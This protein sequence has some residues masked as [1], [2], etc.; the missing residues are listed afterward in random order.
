METS[1]PKIAAHGD[2]TALS[3]RILSQI[4]YI[5]S[6]DLWNDD[7]LRQIIAL[8]D[9]RWV[10]I[11]LV[12]RFNR[13]RALTQD[14]NLVVC[15]LKQSDMFEVDV[16]NFRIRRK[17]PL[18]TFN[19]KR[20]AK[21]CIYADTLPPGSNLD[22]IQ[23]MFSVFGEV[24]RVAPCLSSQLI[25]KSLAKHLKMGT[26]SNIP[27]PAGIMYSEEPHA[28]LIE[29]STKQAAKNAVYA[30]TKFNGLKN[31]PPSTTSRLS[32][33]ETLLEPHSPNIQSIARSLSVSERRSLA[34]FSAIQGENA[35]PPQTLTAEVMR[36][37]EKLSAMCILSPPTVSPLP[38]TP[39]RTSNSEETLSQ[40]TQRDLNAELRESV[41]SM[42][43]DIDPA[44]D[45][46]AEESKDISA[47]TPVKKTQSKLDPSSPAFV[48]MQDRMRLSAVSTNLRNESRDSMCRDSMCSVAPNIDMDSLNLDPFAGTNVT[49]KYAYIRK[50]ERYTQQIVDNK[51]AELLAAASKEKEKKKQR[52]RKKA[53]SASLTNDLDA[54]STQVIAA[55]L[56]A[57]GKLPP[58]DQRRRSSSV[59]STGSQ[60]PEHRASR[61]N[62]LSWRVL[63][64]PSEDLADTEVKGRRS[65]GNAKGM[66]VQSEQ[67][68][69]RRGGREKKE[70]RHSERQE[71][72]R[73]TSESGGHSMRMRHASIGSEYDQETPRKPNTNKRGSVGRRRSTRK[74]STN[75][76]DEKDTGRSMLLSPSTN[77][78]AR[79]KSLLNSK[80]KR[81]AAGPE[82]GSTG[83]C[84]RGRGGVATAAAEKSEE[85]VPLGRGGNAA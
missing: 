30:I 25:S 31:N 38:V 81:F 45:H 58:T 61:S 44:F 85:L 80:E 55:I 71:R 46:D 70:R 42:H 26:T 24:A 79:R 34:S 66:K 14:I 62:S 72:E 48:P 40:N 50:L 36:I 5:F 77:G 53:R 65:H 83:F 63:R 28:V 41:T 21:R 4:E 17:E 82:G 74:A 10:S 37:H 57:Q 20:D 1:S 27:V 76:E 33:D 47:Q 2:V 67:K 23:E 32:M 59:V 16:A 49:T 15:A 52:N 19:P 9:D 3:K 75:A 8:E 54:R 12:S 69:K 51:N 64:S 18:K 73:R 29:F 84:G 60:E 7:Y 78:S 22:S 68:P 11:D 39:E 13:V 35:I 43:S 6:E 56:E